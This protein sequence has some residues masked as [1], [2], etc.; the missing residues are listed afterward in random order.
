MSDYQKRYLGKLGY[1]AGVA[2]SKRD[3]KDITSRGE[4]I[5]RKQQQVLDLILENVFRENQ[6][7]FAKMYE[8]YET[9]NL[10]KTD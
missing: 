1:H 4:K 6:C 10:S 9:T 7:Q 3:Q 5:S 2:Y 8:T